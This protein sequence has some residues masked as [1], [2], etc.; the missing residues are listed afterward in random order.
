MIIDQNSDPGYSYL[1][2]LVKKYPEAYERVK[3]AE[4]NEEQS[5]LPDSVFAWE[6]ERKF[7]LHTPEHATL[8]F[9]YSK[10]GSTPSHVIEKISEALDIY[11]IDRSIVTENVMKIAAPK[12]YIF[13]DKQLYAIETVDD[14]KVAEQR[15]L[16]QVERL[17]VEDRASAFSNLYKFATDLNISLSKESQRYIGIVETDT[18]EVV[19]SLEVRAVATRDEPTRQKFIKFA[20]LLESAPKII[21]DRTV[22]IKI[23]NHVAELDKTAGMSRHYGKQKGIA[24]PITTVFNTHVTTKISDSMVDLNGTS[25]PLTQLAGIDPKTYGDILGPDIVKE[26]STA[27]GGNADPQKLMQL[28]PTLPNDLKSLLAQK[29]TTLLT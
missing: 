5:N 22:Q 17:S 25:F 13:P 11:G 3:T 16:Q 10:L 20:A 2:A 15:L 29:L 6:S 23:A 21:T 26:I 7:P 27:D 1:R 9:L 28:L 14:V 4:L 8:S 12:N 19:A 18:K 24:D